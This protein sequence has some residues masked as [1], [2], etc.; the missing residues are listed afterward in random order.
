MIRLYLPIPVVDFQPIKG[1]P[2]L[3]EGLRELME[4]ADQYVLGAYAMA[5]EELGFDFGAEPTPLPELVEYFGAEA[6]EGGPQS[7]ASLRTWSCTCT[8][9]CEVCR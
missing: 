3:E 4:W 7:V 8:A 9:G 2:Q 5:P 1:D 6:F